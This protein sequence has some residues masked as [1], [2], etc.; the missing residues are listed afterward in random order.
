MWPLPTLWAK[1]G[2]AEAGRG[3]WLSSGGG[4]AVCGLLAKA[5]WTALPRGLCAWL[6]GQG[7]E[8]GPLDVRWG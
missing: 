1:W 5:L 2:E 6:E 3:N 7:P 4:L 8:W